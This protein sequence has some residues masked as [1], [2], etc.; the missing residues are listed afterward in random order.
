MKNTHISRA[1]RAVDSTHV[2]VVKPDQNNMGD[3]ILPELILQVGVRKGTGVIC[4]SI[5]LYTKERLE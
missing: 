1:A 4:I 5:I 3:V 2:L